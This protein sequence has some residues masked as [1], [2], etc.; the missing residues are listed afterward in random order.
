VLVR[1]E[2]IDLFADGS[3]IKAT[4]A[5]HDFHGHDALV[6]L[7]LADGTEVTARTHGGTRA[8]ALGEE[9]SIAVGAPPASSRD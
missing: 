3:S 5:R 1:P 4:V 6:A 8:P 9:V 2:Q 7:R